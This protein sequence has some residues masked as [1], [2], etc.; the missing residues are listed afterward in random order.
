MVT[1]YNSDLSKELRDGTKNQQLRDTLPTQL[2]D[3]VVPVMEVNPRMLRRITFLKGLGGTGTTTI[4]T[5]P[6]DKEFYLVGCS[7]SICKVV[8][9]TGSVGYLKTTQDGVINSVISYA[10]VTTTADS[11]TI[12]RDFSL[13]IKIDKNTAITITATGAFTRI[14]ANI[15]GYFVENINS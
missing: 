5:T 7:L 13:P 9:D 4:Y 3:K 8:G 10:G 6:V 12:S 2:A 14:E 11:Q 1:I 15:Q